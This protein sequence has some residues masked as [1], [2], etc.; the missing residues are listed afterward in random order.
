[1]LRD[2]RYGGASKATSSTVCQKCLK[3]GHYSY[4]CKATP[5]DRPY[6][7]RPSRTQQLM[8]PKLVPQLTSDVPNELNRK[9]GVAD[10][11]LAQLAASRG[12]KRF[13]SLNDNDTSMSPDRKRSRSRSVS[14]SSTTSVATISTRSSRSRTPRRDVA[15]DEDRYL[16]SQRS[17]DLTFPTRAVAAHHSKQS[18][19][20]RRRR[21]TSSHSSSDED[22][23]ADRY[24]GTRESS[25]DRE[26]ERDRNTRRRRAS[27]SP[28]RRG[29]AR[30]RSRSRGRRMS[31]TE[32]RVKAR[33]G[34]RDPYGEGEGH[35]IGRGGRERKDR[36]TGERET[37][38]FDEESAKKPR[39]KSQR[40]QR[41]ERSL[42]PYSRR[43]ALTQAL[44]RGGS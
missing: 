34:R 11:H 17:D 41:K 31:S 26:R 4:E 24:K 8:N 37:K 14:T 27:R 3:R 7:A 5:Q 28:T 1:M 13:R 25:R 10:E 6:A 20:K 15:G 43:L 32:G 33:M 21:S 22:D 40:Q 29:R 35:R 30:S 42:S 9:I 23:E 18:D 44:G 2:R 19:R 38:H 12:R 39:H 36:A 16:M